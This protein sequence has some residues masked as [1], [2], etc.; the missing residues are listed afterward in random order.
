MD[1]LNM[2]DNIDTERFSLLKLTKKI[3]FEFRV[4]TDGQDRFFIFG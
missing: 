1:S 3:T 2:F 4:D